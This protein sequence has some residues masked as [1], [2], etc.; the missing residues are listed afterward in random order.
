MLIDGGAAID[1]ES[2]V[3][4]GVDCVSVLVKMGVYVHVYVILLVHAMCD[5]VTDSL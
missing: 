1:F 2:T 4:C 3:S 5:C